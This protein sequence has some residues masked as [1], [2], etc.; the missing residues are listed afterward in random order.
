[1]VLED[2]LGGALVYWDMTSMNWD[3]T[4]GSLVSAFGNSD[5]ELAWVVGKCWAV[6]SIGLAAALYGGGADHERTALGMPSHFFPHVRF[7]VLSF[8]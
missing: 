5:A 6:G 1:V 3:K 4:F 7:L 2:C 8:Q